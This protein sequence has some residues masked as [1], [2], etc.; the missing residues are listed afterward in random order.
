[1]YNNTPCLGNHST[2]VYFFPRYFT[3]VKRSNYFSH[4]SFFSEADS[5]LFLKP[6]LLGVSILY[7]IMW[8]YARPHSHHR[9]TKSMTNHFLRCYPFFSIGPTSMIS[10]QPTVPGHPEQSWIWTLVPLIPDFLNMSRNLKV[11]ECTK[12]HHFAA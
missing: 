7:I 12:L 11:V 4:Q 9:R 1:M 6:K 3:K 5:L 8:F 2:C 10:S